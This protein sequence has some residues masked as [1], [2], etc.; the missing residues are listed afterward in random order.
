[1]MDRSDWPQISKEIYEANKDLIDRDVDLEFREWKEG[2]FFNSG[3]FAGQLSKV[4]LANIP[5]D[6]LSYDFEDKYVPAQFFAGWYYG[7]TT[8]DKRDKILDCYEPSEEITNLLNEG[9]QEMIDG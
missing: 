7:F 4:F 2:V 6:E 5:T 8:H 3:M 1:M 9:M